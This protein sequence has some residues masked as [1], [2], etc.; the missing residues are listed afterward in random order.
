MGVGVS[1]GGLPACWIVEHHLARFVE[2]GKAADLG[3]MWDQMWRSTLHYGR[4][5][6]VVNA[7][8]AVDPAMWDLLGRL[9]GGPAYSLLGG[10]APGKRPCYPPRPRPPLAHERGF[11]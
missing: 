11:F 3:V 6:L 1:R 8:S 2:G 10:A 5:G 7:I 9:R 4:Q